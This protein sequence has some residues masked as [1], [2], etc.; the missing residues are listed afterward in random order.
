MGKLERDNNIIMNRQIEED[1]EINNKVGDVKRR[2]QS[3]E[4]TLLKIVD[5]IYNI[6]KAC[7]DNIKVLI[8]KIEVRE[9]R[10]RNIHP[11]VKKRRPLRIVRGKGPDLA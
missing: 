9:T 6:L 4:G 1:K 8:T 2:V 3:I 7:N 10:R 11:T 5:Q